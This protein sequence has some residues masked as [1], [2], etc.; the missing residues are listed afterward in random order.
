MEDSLAKPIELLSKQIAFLGE[1][2]KG[3]Q[4]IVPSDGGSSFKDKEVLTPNLTPTETN[5]EKQKAIIFGKALG[6]GV[7]T[8]KGKLED[9]TPDAI[10]AVTASATVAKQQEA[11]MGILKLIGGILGVGANLLALTSAYKFLREWIPKIF[12]PGSK[13]I[14]DTLDTFFQPIIDFV[15]EM[16]KQFMDWFKETFPKTYKFL[17]DTFNTV[18]QFFVDVKE[19]VKQNIN[20]VLYDKDSPLSDSMKMSLRRLKIQFEKLYDWFIEGDRSMDRKPW[21]VAWLDGSNSK[22]KTPIFELWTNI[23]DNLKIITDNLVMMVTRPK[24]YAYN[25][26]M[27]G[28]GM[29]TADEM[30]AER[31]KPIAPSRGSKVDVAMNMVPGG[32]F[33]L[34]ALRFYD[35]LK[36]DDIPAR[37]LLMNQT[38]SYQN[39][40]LEL[41]SGKL[42]NSK[43]EVPAFY[44]NYKGPYNDAV[45]KNGKVYGISNDDDIMAL[46]SGGPLDRIFKKQ[47]NMMVSYS[48]SLLEATMRQI[49]L[50]AKIETNTAMSNQFLSKQKP[51][52]VQTGGNDSSKQRIFNRKAYDVDTTPLFDYKLLA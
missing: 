18:K 35:W 48:R 3:T 26:L 45:F 8:P 1:K 38:R 39:R 52:I 49:E 14:F 42:K 37:N 32:T 5:R 44:E 40:M 22:F 10:K 2:I 12:G 7:Y 46:K 34:Q 25:L 47:D 27:Y 51:T 11:G 15:D 28:K 43:R 30:A 9:L 6:I 31:A 50:L 33:T 19:S 36:S 20:W 21:I 17:N 4:S 24:D 29:P 16:K 41:Q 23:T 13:G